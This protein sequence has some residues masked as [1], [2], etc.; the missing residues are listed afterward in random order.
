MKYLFVLAF[1]MLCLEGRSQLTNEAQPE[2]DKAAIEFTPGFSL[3]SLNIPGN[4]KV[5][6]DVLLGQRK[7][8]ISSNH[9]WTGGLVFLAGA[10]KGF[11]ETLQFHWK[12]FRRQFPGANAQ[13]FNP[14][15]SWRNKYKNGDPE[16]GAKFFG[17]TSVFIMFTDQY[18]LNNFI[19]R[20]AWGTAMV[21]KIGEGKK[22]FKQ[23]LLDFLYY[24]ICHQAGFAA[25]YYPFSKY[26]GK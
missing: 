17:S 1:A 5:K 20:A 8:K 21:I 15:L 11:N 25:T 24:G 10:A 23:Y 16:A 6:K 9:I 14:S 12:E 3:T 19:N 4:D 18:H 22:P 13:W 2:P 26:K 7:W